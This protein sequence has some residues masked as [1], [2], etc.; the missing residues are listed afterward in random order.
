MGNQPN[1]EAPHSAYEK[2]E[3]AE[4]QEMARRITDEIVNIASQVRKTRRS[5]LI[6]L[7]GRKALPYLAI[8]S[9]AIPGDRIA[10][11]RRNQDIY[12][13]AISRVEEKK[14]KITGF[15]DF[16]AAPLVR[17]TAT[18]YGQVNGAPAVREI[19][20]IG[21][22]GCVIRETVMGEDGHP[23]DFSAVFEWPAEA[24]LEENNRA[25]FVYK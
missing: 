13:T 21:S 2:D 22:T 24:A 18:S 15:L 5:R 16:Y 25:G 10:A 17:N 12:E 8:P 3:W 14:R 1:H 7:H 6:P 4:D 9:E 11:Y 19:N 20:M 23:V